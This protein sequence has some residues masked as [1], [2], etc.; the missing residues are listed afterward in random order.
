S[1]RGP[2]CR[3]AVRSIGWELWRKTPTNKIRMAFKLTIAAGGC[4]RSRVQRQRFPLY[5]ERK[6]YAKVC[7]RAGDTR[8]RENVAGRATTGCDEVS[9][10]SE[11]PGPQNPVAS[12]LCDRR[13]ALLHL[14]GTGRR[15]HPGARP[16]RRLSGQPD[17]G[18]TSTARR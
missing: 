15:D 8:S 17:L 16:A 3:C 11:E 5:Y 14:P 4:P 10:G 1:Y 18:S 6:L 13:Q 9:R 2:K 12:Q 7:S